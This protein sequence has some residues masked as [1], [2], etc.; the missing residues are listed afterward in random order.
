MTAHPLAIEKLGEDLLRRAAG[1]ALGGA[2]EAR[3]ARS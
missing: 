1:A 2:R 3:A